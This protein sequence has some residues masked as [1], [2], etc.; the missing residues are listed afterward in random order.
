MNGVRLEQVNEFVY[1]GSILS[2]DGRIDREIERQ[3][4]ASCRVLGALGTFARNV[5]ATRVARLSVYNGVLVPA[6]QP[7]WSSGLERSVYR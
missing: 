5:N 2:R 3:V 1:L 7:L 6:L 4:S